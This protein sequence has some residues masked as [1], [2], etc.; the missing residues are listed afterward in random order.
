MLHMLAHSSI[1]LDIEKEVSGYLISDFFTVNGKKFEMKLLNEEESA[2]VFSLVNPKNSVAL[3]LSVRL[4]N[5]A[6]GIRSINDV[7]VNLIMSQKYEALSE[8]ELEIRFADTDQKF[9]YAELL[10]DWLKELPPE[11]IG[12][13]YAK[14]QALEMRREKAHNELKNSSREGSAKA[15]KKSLTE[16]SQSG[17]K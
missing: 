8:N 11:Y 6:I 5:L 1:L 13:L 2:W 10:Y 7:P 15:T 9:I 12:E 4:G 16:P 14:W 17:D 3:A